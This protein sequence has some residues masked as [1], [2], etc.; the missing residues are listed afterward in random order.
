MLIMIL[1]THT[2]TKNKILQYLILKYIFQYNLY[3]FNC[4]YTLHK[5]NYLH[6]EKIIEFPICFCTI[7]K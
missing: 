6:D 1:Q 2:K 3:I 5:V 7:F 4:I